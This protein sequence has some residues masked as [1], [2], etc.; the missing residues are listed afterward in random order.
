MV[1]ARNGSERNFV[2]VH[3]QPRTW[4]S[5]WLGPEQKARTA[6]PRTSAQRVLR[7]EAECIV[8]RDQLSL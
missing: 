8:L 6:D 4:T 3:F 2:R 1:N 7:L 5:W